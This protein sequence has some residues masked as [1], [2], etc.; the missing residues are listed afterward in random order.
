MAI[1][2]ELL[3]EDHDDY[4]QSMNNLATMYQ[5]MGEYA[6]AEPLLRCAEEISRSVL[7]EHHPDYAS[8]LNNL[9]SLYQD[10]GD[11]AKAEPEFRHAMEILKA[12]R[13]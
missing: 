3:G 11:Y 4:A 7:G 8:S 2:G 9:A 1:R 12:S 6:K 13:G 5:A 10:A